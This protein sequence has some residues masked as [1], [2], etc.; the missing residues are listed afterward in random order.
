M[1]RCVPFFGFHC[2]NGMT[3]PLLWRFVLVHLPWPLIGW[4]FTAIGDPEVIG[5]HYWSPNNWNPSPKGATPQEHAAKG[6]L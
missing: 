4:P 1:I 3:L 6:G 2:W 5:C